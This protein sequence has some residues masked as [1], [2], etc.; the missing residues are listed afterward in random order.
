MAIRISFNSHP[1]HGTISFGKDHGKT[2]TR[3]VK[4]DRPP[5]AVKRRG[6]RA[7]YWKCGYCGDHTRSRYQF[8]PV[9]KCRCLRVEWSYTG[10]GP[11]ARDSFNWTSV[12]LRRAFVAYAEQV[13]WKANMTLGI[14]R[15]FVNAKHLWWWEVLSGDT[16]ISRSAEYVAQSDTAKREAEE[17]ALEYW[18]KHHNSSRLWRRS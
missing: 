6:R 9:R 7:H 13:Y 5:A 11:N 8:A 17:A 2:V 4:P 10:Y 18:N 3:K 15:V 16:I 1:D 14:V 12:H